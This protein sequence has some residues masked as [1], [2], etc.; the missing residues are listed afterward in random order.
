MQGH[1]PKW[2]EHGLPHDIEHGVLVCYRSTGLGIF[3][4]AAR[5]VGMPLEK[6]ALVMNSSQVSGSGQLQQAFRIT[7]AE[8]LLA[9]YKVVGR[10][11]LVAWFMQYSVMGFVFQVCDS[12]LSKAMGVPRVLYGEELMLSS[13]ERDKRQH[14]AAICEPGMSHSPPASEA[15]LTAAKATL[16]PLLAGTIESAVANRAEVQRYFGIT[17]FAKI[18]ARLNWD[19]VRRMCGPAFLANASR[20]FIMSST[21]FVITPLLFAHY[22]PQEHKSQQS[23]F[24]FGLGVNIFVGNQIAITQQALWGRALDYAAHQGGRPINYPAVITQGLKA[25]GIRAFYTPAKWCVAP[26]SA[27]QA[28]WPRICTFT[29]LPLRTTI[30]TR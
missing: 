1:V 16:A 17:Q 24:W 18:E 21:S 23:L 19:V 15:A 12:V 13:E 6:V 9:P 11:S 22:Y 10:A 3:G 26:C 29:P 14:T 25:E 27:H 7:F 5:W 20:N 2:W 30:L 28:A 8:G 4:A